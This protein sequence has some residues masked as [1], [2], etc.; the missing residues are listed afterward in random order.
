MT[1]QTKYFDK[2]NCDLILVCVCPDFQD[3]AGT[4]QRRGR[5]SPDAVHGGTGR[6]APCSFP[7][8]VSTLLQTAQTV[9]SKLSQESGQFFLVKGLICY[10]LL[11]FE[12]H[13]Q[14]IFRIEAVF[15]L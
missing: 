6:P 13:F 14:V 12:I 11:F 2:N 10:V 15:F 4:V 9:I 5:R 7:T 8:F 3:P 1:E